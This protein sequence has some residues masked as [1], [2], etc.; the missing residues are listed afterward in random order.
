MIKNNL[1]TF[2]SK[3]KH[4]NETLFLVFFCLVFSSIKKN[5]STILRIIKSFTVDLPIAYANIRVLILD[6]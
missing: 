6:I 3:N 2:D 1:L 4:K 5:I